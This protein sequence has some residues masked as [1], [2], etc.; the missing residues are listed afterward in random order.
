MKLTKTLYGKYKRNKDGGV[1]MSGIKNLDKIGI[2]KGDIVGMGYCIENESF[3]AVTVE[4][5]YTFPNGQSK[6]TQ[7]KSDSKG[8]WASILNFNEIVLVN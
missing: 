5:K 2:R 7:S 6:V 4:K 1:A 3:V 8:E